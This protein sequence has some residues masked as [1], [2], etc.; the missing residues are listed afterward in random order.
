MQ[1]LIE[2]LTAQ[3]DR[4]Y[5]ERDFDMDSVSVSSMVKFVLYHASKILGRKPDAIL[6]V[7]CG[8]GHFSHAFAVNSAAEVIGIDLSME[9]VAG[10]A[11]NYS[12]DNRAFWQANILK[13][14]ES[15]PLRYDLIY[16]RDFP[17]FNA[18]RCADDQ[19]H[20]TLDHI[21]RLMG[22]HSVMIIDEWTDFSGR[23]PKEGYKKGWHNRTQEEIRTCFLDYTPIHCLAQHYIPYPIW[24]DTRSGYLIIYEKR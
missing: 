16:L 20:D 1:G 21:S 10:A 22:D 2:K 8:K 15:E 3:Y 13:Y 23:I 6:D 14:A 11:E 18:K 4:F 7:G 17:L 9:A 12:E 5:S 19:I 24:S